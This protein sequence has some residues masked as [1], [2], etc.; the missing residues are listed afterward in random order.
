MKPN[1]K[2]SFQLPSFFSIRTAKDLGE[3]FD[4]NALELLDNE[5]TVFDGV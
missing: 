1:S 2:E 4:G 5:Q 3:I